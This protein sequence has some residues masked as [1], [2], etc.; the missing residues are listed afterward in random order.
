MRRMCIR[1]PT[2]PSLPDLTRFLQLLAAI[3]PRSVS[4]VHVLAGATDAERASNAK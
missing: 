3:S 1:C 2:N 4:P